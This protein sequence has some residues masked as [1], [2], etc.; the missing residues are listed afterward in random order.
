VSEFY[1]TDSAVGLR[2]WPLI[3]NYSRRPI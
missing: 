2:I 1:Q 3:H